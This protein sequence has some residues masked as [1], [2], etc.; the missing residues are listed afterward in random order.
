MSILETP[1]FLRRQQQY[2]SP[3][4]ENTPI[5]P[6]IAPAALDTR[7]AIGRAANKWVGIHAQDKPFGAAILGMQGSGK[8]SL[9][10]RTIMDDAFDPNC[11]MIVMDPKSDLTR[12]ALSVIPPSR[13]VW[14]LQLANPQFGINPLLLN[15]SPDAIARVIVATLRDIHGDD[16]IRASS[17]RYLYFAVL[18]ALRYA[19]VHNI[20]PTLHFVRALLWPSEDELRAKVASLCHADPQW[21]EVA[22]FFGTEFPGDLSGSRSQVTNLLMAPRNKLQLLFSQ[23]LD[24]VIR[25]P[26]QVSLEQIIRNRD[27]LIVDG[28][29]GQMGSEG[30]TEMVMKL[31]TRQIHAVLARI[32]QDT[33]LEQRPRVALKIDEAHLVLSQTFAF[34]MAVFRS[35]GLETMAALQYTAQ[36]VEDDVRAAW[37]NLLGSRFAFRVRDPLEAEQIARLAMDRYSSSVRVD[38]EDRDRMGITPD[39][40]LRMPTFYGVASMIAKGEPQRSFT[41]KTIPTTTNEPLIQ[42][43]LEQQLDRGCHHITSAPPPPLPDIE[44]PH[45]AQLIDA[46]REPRPI[47]VGE[48]LG[49]LV[50]TITNTTTAAKQKPTPVAA[51]EITDPPADIDPAQ[52]T[53]PDTTSITTLAAIDDNQGGLTVKSESE[54]R[55]ARAAAIAMLDQMPIGELL[56]PAI[57]PALM[58]LLE[59]DA[60]GVAWDK[61]I[62]HAAGTVDQTLAKIYKKEPGAVLYMLALLY[63]APVMT[64][65]QLA[66]ISPWANASDPAR[67]VRDAFGLLYKAGLVRRVRFR[68]TKPGGEPWNYALTTAAVSVLKTRTLPDSDK[69]YLPSYCTEQ[70]LRYESK[71]RLEHDLRAVGWMLAA[72]HYAGRQAKEWHGPFDRMCA[73]KPD[74]LRTPN[75]RPGEDLRIDHL[76]KHGDTFIDGFHCDQFRAFNADGMIALRLKNGRQV[77]LFLEFDRSGPYH[78]YEK[79]ENY[80]QLITGW[81]MMLDRYQALGTP[82]V[83]TFVAADAHGARKLARA[84]DEHVTARTGKIGTSPMEHQ[85]PARDRMFFAAEADIYQGTFRG[86]MLP[87]RPPELRKQLGDSVEPEF[88]QGALIPAIECLRTRY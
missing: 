88:R 10:L 11:A 81:A 7:I 26:H 46:E 40:F 57:P 77:D 51:T 35:A 69:T 24:C 60:Q 71:S 68:S 75:K 8:T 85:F 48:M 63:R 83:V 55:E 43:H 84:A 27:I 62:E 52:P 2:L 15:A 82:P 86:L 22:R 19:Q 1:E 39:T 25:H 54:T 53:E 61:T 9:L 38:D 14:F 30:A 78:N 80:D 34:M 31:I 47:E 36:L 56:D 6:Y 28:T 37:L 20:E 66:R 42:R 67:R 18:A 33:P 45:A 29:M 72:R 44:D 79:F 5:A 59:V 12:T 17:E 58:D 49:N 87:A 74:K 32:Q 16:S 76:P 70:R 21:A 41:L 13:R 3:R 4:D 64:L 23:Q 73:M 65:G 50:D